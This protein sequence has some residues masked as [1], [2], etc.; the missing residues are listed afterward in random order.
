MDLCKRNFN[1]GSYV[2]G[3]VLT[4]TIF[5]LTINNYSNEGFHTLELKCTAVPYMRPIDAS[6]TKLT[7]NLGADNFVSDIQLKKEPVEWK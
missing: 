7:F 4:A 3:S 5:K 2:G 1:I 6:I